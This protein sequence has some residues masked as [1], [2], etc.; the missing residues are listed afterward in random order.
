MPPFGQ[1]R[2][3]VGAE[4]HAGDHRYEENPEISFAQPEKPD[5]EDRCTGDVEELRGEAERRRERQPRERTVRGHIAHVGEDRAHLQRRP[6]LFGVRLGQPEG[7]QSQQ[8]CGVAGQEEEDDFPVAN[9]Q[10]PAADHRCQRGRDTE[11]HRDLSHHSLRLPAVIEITDKRPGDDLGGAREDALNRPEDQQHGQA[12]GQGTANR[13]EREGGHARNHDGLASDRIGDRAVEQTREG[14]AEQIDAGDLL[15]SGIRGAELY[16][17]ACKCWEDGINGERSD[18]R[19]HRH[20]DRRLQANTFA[21]R[22]TLRAGANSLS[23][24]VRS[25]DHAGSSVSHLPPV[26]AAARRPTSTSQ[27]RPRG[28]RKVQS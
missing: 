6:F 24:P 25:L 12:G 2:I 19:Q 1:P 3:H 4:N 9:R 21:H 26:G 23:G 8:Q 13:G 16:P 11:D 17:D 14:V 22:H 20:D 7:D 10:Q 5:D 27:L 18:H 28:C 15:K